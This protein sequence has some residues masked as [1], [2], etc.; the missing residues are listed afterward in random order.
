MFECAR[1]LFLTGAP[2]FPLDNKQ[3]QV[4]VGMLLCLISM[5]IYIDFKPYRKVTDSQFGIVAQVVLSL[6]PISV[7]RLF[8][9][10]QCQFAIAS[11]RM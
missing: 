1:R 2:L 6:T 7:W 9:V 8:K 11:S 10:A 3:S 4:A 5:C